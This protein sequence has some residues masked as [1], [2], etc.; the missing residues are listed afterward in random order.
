MD[1]I[2]TK[3]KEFFKK[4]GNYNYCDLGEMI[5]T[6]SIA[7]DTET[8]GLECYYTDEGF[9][10]ANI[11]AI[12]IGTGKN[13]YL[14][15]LQS[16]NNG[17]VVEEIIPYLKDRILIGHNLTF[18]LRFLYK[19]NFFP[20]KIYD[21]FI[22]SKLLYNGGRDYVFTHDFGSVM[23]RELNLK[24]DKSEQ[25][26]IANVQLRTDKAIQY[27]FNDVD[28]LLDL[29][30][31]LYRKIKNEKSIKS[32]ELNCNF[33]RALSYIEMCG[34]P[35]NEEKWRKK[36]IQDEKDLENIQKEITQYIFDNLPKYRDLQLDL[37]DD[38]DKIIVNLDS[39][40]QMIPV[41]KD[42]GI[43]VINSVGKESIKE[44]V[45][46]KSKHEFVNIWKKYQ[47]ISQNLSTFG[48][49]ILDKVIKGRIYTSFNPMV[50]TCRPSSKKGGI[51][52]L[53]FP[54]DERTRLCFEAK[55]G[56]SIVGA[57]YEGQENTTG[58]DLH[59]DKTMVAS[60]NEGKCLHSA[61]ARLLFPEISSLSDKEIKDSHSDKR[62][63]AKA[64]RFAFAYGGN[65][66][67]ISVNENIPMA[68]A[69]EIEELFKQLH[70]GIYSWGEKVY[71]QA[72]KV[73]YIESA[74]GWKLWL[75][76]FDQFKHD[77][78]WIESLDSDYWGQYRSGKEQYRKKLENIKKRKEG[79]DI[80]E[81]SI[82]NQFTYEIYLKDKSKVS[83][84]FKMKS[85]YFRL[86]LN[87]PV[88][89][90]SAH[91]TKGGIIKLFDTIVENNDIWKV[92]ICNIPYDELVLEV[93]DELAE[94]YKSIL[95][96]SMIEEGNK[97]LTSGIVKL[98]AEAKIGKSWGNVH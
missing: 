5:L 68:R 26:N 4:I 89:S 21:T 45:I 57:D 33:V 40:K 96:N 44:D 41:F 65:A 29:A 15:D 92:K 30:R 23:E 46:N 14:I 13:N 54:S 76:E 94:K 37:W 20:K 2:I 28:R 12:Q 67:T 50:D 58:A 1:Y 53:N 19:H 79:E 84:F 43:N 36:I 59:R 34:L 24:Y 63:A 18:D 32:Y 35:L 72:V 51:N 47:G 55:K 71:E 83:N 7:I 9:K 70:S 52:F 64:P 69:T 87:N 56:Y 82:E 3:N 66:F 27:C 6:P 38:S 97:W 93:K 80:D 61:F 8:T 17:Y 90:T 98:D 86:C 42:F 31:L 60:V 78:L 16:H 25:K 62:Q 39:P 22:A 85:R 77:K 10:G 95:E 74:G 75:P 91:E 48:Q 88:Q 81:Y 49:N 73:G 11:F